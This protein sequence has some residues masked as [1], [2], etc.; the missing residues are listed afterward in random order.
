MWKRKCHGQHCT[1]LLA[2]PASLEWR[3]FAMASMEDWWDKTHLFVQESCS[4]ERFPLVHGGDK[5][6]PG[7]GLSV[8]WGTSGVWEAGGICLWDEWWEKGRKAAMGVR[9]GEWRDFTCNKER[10]KWRV[11]KENSIR[12]R[13]AESLCLFNSIKRHYHRWKENV[14]KGKR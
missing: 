13:E 4:Q 2:A 10:M 9:R 6:A 14:A 5:G 11:V 7:A 8:R 3:F 12:K 1:P